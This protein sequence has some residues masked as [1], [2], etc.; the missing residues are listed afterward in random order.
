MTCCP[1]CYAQILTEREKLLLAQEAAGKNRP[2]ITATVTC[3]YCG[4][5]AEVRLIFN[6]NVI[7]HY[8]TEVEKQERMQRNFKTAESNFCRI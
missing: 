8:K 6:L 1:N 7:G 3:D 4:Q 2:C 5:E